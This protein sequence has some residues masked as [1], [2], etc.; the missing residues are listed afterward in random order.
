MK[1]R[2]LEIA[3]P[4]CGSGEVFYSCTPNCCFN[5]VCGNCGTTFEPATKAAGGSVA[6]LIPPDPL[7]D[8]TDPTAEC[9]RCHSITVYLTEDGRVVCGR[10]GAILELEL[11]EV[12]PG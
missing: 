10:C 4:Q 9:A 12:A 11:T 1:T 5:H 2:K 3:C 7:P 6:G 8:A